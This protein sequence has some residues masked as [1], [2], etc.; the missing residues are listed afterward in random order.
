MKRLIPKIFTLTFLTAICF[1]MSGQ[2]DPELRKLKFSGNKT[3]SNKELSSEISFT[4]ATWTGKKLFGKT[5][6]YFN[7]EAY[8]MNVR[9]LRHFYQSEGFI[10][11]EIGEPIVKLRR[12]GRKAELTIPLSEGEPVVIDSVAFSGPDTLMNK[13]LLELLTRRRSLLQ[14]RVGERF[15]DNLIWNDRDLITRRMVEN[16]YAYA[17][18][19]P[20]IIADTTVN[21]AQVIWN[22]SPGPKS[23][24]GETSISGQQRTPEHIIRRQLAYKPGDVYSREKLNRSQQQIYQLGTFRIAS[25]RAM[26]S[27]DMKDTIP[28]QINITEA[29]RTSTRVGVGYGREDQFRTFVDFQVL[30]FTG[31]ARRLNLYAKHSALEPYRVEATLTQPAAFSPNSTVAFSPS[32]K[33]QK[34]P[35]YELFSYSS[36]LALLNKITDKLSGSLN[37]YS[38]TVRLDTTSLALIEDLTVLNRTYTKTGAATGFLYDNARPR[39]DPARGWTVAV[40]AKANTSMF[41]GKYPFLKYQFEA[42][43]YQRIS[44]HLILALKLKAGTVNPTGSTKTIP[45]EE[46]FFAGGSRSVRGWGRQQLGPADESGIPAGGKSMIEASFEP[47]I[48]IAGPLSIVAFLDA[49]NVWSQATHFTLSEIRYAAGGGIR[50]STPIGPIGVDVARP[51]WDDSAKWQFHLNIGHAF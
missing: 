38:E 34:E 15:Q 14:V 44:D 1:N 31:G 9:E 37:F 32:I 30:N 16:G 40:N 28:V 50:F 36:N 10:H 22:L 25:V 7:S 48:K 43:N 13:R 33:K 24:F 39:F 18:L 41:S 8:N 29:P 45:V 3:Y 2:A 5:P 17:E 4:A 11:I 47:R 42:K 35:G 27:R 49:G 21:A 12:N 51:V 20:E 46:R 23:Y 19:E 26:L 6:S